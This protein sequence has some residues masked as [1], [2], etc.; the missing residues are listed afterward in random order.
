MG[1]M[2]HI[3]T[4]FCALY[5]GPT[6][7]HHINTRGEKDFQH[8]C[9]GIKHLMLQGVIGDTFNYR[10][11]GAAVIDDPEAQIPVDAN[12]YPVFPDFTYEIANYFSSPRYNMAHQITHAVISARRAAHLASASRPGS[13]V[14]Q[15]RR[16]LENAIPAAYGMSAAA[17]NFQSVS[18]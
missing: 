5:S 11:K 2:C 17:R 3:C 10:S 14:A 18:A 7:P 6:Y 1:Q 12:V 8:A 9:S 15:R 13:V 16:L 4:Y